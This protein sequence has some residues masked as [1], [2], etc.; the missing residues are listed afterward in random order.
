LRSLV[1]ALAAVAAV[2][3]VVAAQQWIVDDDGPADFSYLQ[4]AVDAYYVHSGDV[5]LV[6]PGRYLGN[7]VVGSKDLVILSEA[8]PFATV[9]DAQG[10]GSAIVLTN[11]SAATRI[12]GFTVTGGRDQIG[13]G[14]YVYGGAPVITRNLIVDNEAVG[15]YL[16]Y[17]YGGG[18]EVYSAAPTITHNVIRG[19]TALDGG[20]GIDVYY[21]GP[22][23]SGTCCPRIERNTI[24]GNAVTSPSGRGGGILVFASAPVVGANVL[25]ANHAA[26]GGGLFV[27]KVQGNPDVPDVTD[28]VFHGNVP[29]AADSSSGWRLPSS[30][31]EIDPRLGAGPGGDVWPR[32]NSPLLDALPS[33]TTTTDLSGA[34]AVQDSDLD[35]V[36]V[37]DVGAIEGRGEI[38]AL[39]L[40][41]HPDWPWVTVL[42]WDG[43]VSPAA[44]FHVLRSVDGPFVDDGGVCVAG[45]LGATTHTDGDVPDAEAAF[46]YLVAGHDV[47][48]GSTGARSDG[49]PRPAAQPCPGE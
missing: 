39:S 10:S 20:G 46:Y 32:S 23:T 25:L 34:A 49:T 35:G 28:D 13:G 27:E 21:A 22:S 5:I 3:A 31:R 17:G 45:P 26:A 9:L 19:N 7:V 44:H 1:A 47:V 16:G 43:L 48:L 2:R 6:R 33:S 37:A 41:R 12:E 42:A 18:I 15:G 36:A 29:D 38:T 14:I 4:S 11:R 24:V 30:N 40:S 8:G